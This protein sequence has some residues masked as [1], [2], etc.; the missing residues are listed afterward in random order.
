MVGCILNL[1]NQGGALFGSQDISWGHVA[2]NFVVPFCVA[3]WSAARNQTSLDVAAAPGRERLG[4]SD[5]PVRSAH[6]D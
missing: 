2:L 4:S 1:I 5:V 3:T 6:A